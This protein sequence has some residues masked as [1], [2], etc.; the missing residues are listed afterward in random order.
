[1]AKNTNKIIAGITATAIGLSATFVAV[2]DTNNKDKVQIGTNELTLEEFKNQKGDIANKMKNK[3]DNM[4]REDE[5]THCN[6]F[7][8]DGLCKKWIQT[9][10]IQAAICGKR[11]RVSGEILRS[12]LV[13]KF[14]NI[15]LN[16]C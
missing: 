5:S 13:E 10:N 1:M 3:I 7:D 12:K 9:A 6:Y 14:N 16:G 11:V 15:I 2:N 4:K 8:P